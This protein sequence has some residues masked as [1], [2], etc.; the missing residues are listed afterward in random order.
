MKKTLFALFAA[1]SVASCQKA[2]FVQDIF[3]QHQP[4]D[5]TVN[6]G[7]GAD[8]T[9]TRVNAAGLDFSWAAGD[10]IGLFAG[11]DNCN[12]PF[13]LSSGQGNNWGSFTGKMFQATSQTLYYY[14]PFDSYNTNPSNWQV[15]LEGQVYDGDYTEN[16]TSPNF[17]KFA[18]MNGNPTAGFSISKSTGW[19][20]GKNLEFRY[21]YSSIVRFKISNSMPADVTIDRIEIV[22]SKSGI[23]YDIAYIDITSN[24]LGYSS[25]G[26]IGIDLATPLVLKAGGKSGD[27]Y[28]HMAALFSNF[29]TGTDIDIVAYGSTGGNPVKLVC[30]KHVTA[31]HNFT[32]G[33]RTTI[34]LPLT[35]STPREYSHLVTIGQNGGSVET[36]EFSKDGSDYKAI[37]TDWGDGNREQYYGGSSHQYSKSGAHTVSVSC[38]GTSNSVRFDNLE[39][40]SSIDFSKF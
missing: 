17:G 9:Q 21:R 39:N 29:G 6:A 22:S 2:D 4:F 32:I 13:T 19:P 27:K 8:T 12:V 23:L 37:L 26:T 1:L 3:P 28:V 25:V 38:W 35:D 16:G 33:Y 20:A 14:Y 34:T 5:V 30:P 24:S 36:P 11:P 40:I 18:F 15:T 31:E 7:M 10:R